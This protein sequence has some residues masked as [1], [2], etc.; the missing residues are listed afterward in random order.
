MEQCKEKFAFVDLFM[1]GN[2]ALMVQR[3]MLCGRNRTYTKR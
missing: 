3:G 1:T 2:S